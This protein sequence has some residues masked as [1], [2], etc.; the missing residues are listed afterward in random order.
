[1]L[2]LLKDSLGGPLATMQ[3]RHSLVRLKPLADQRTWPAGGSSYLGSATPIWLMVSKS[4]WS[5]CICLTAPSN[6]FWS[7]G[8]VTPI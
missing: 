3:P 5:S 8:S 1:M 6:F 2:P 4:I 7:D